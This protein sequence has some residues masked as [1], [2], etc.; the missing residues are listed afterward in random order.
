M[1]NMT[2]VRCEVRTEEWG[3]TLLFTGLE[4]F[5]IPP[6]RRCAGYPGLPAPLF[7][8]LVTVYAPE[9]PR[10]RRNGARPDPWGATPGHG[11]NRHRCGD[12]GCKTG[13]C[14]CRPIPRRVTEEQ[15]VS[16]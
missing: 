1:V 8:D 2:A 5:D 4:A 3:D 6:I 9:P 7:T 12:C 15:G 14:A 11:L 16:A 10:Y 13:E